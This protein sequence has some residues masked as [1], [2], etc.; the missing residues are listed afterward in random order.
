M[1][2]VFKI[3]IIMVLL[4][5]A[6]VALTL[7]LVTQTNLL[8]RIAERLLVT[9]VESRYDLNVSFGSIG[10][11]LWHDVTIEDV[12]LDFELAPHRY[13]LARIG[14]LRAYYDLRELLAGRW[15]VDSLIIESPVVVLRADTTGKLLLPKLGAEGGGDGVQRSLNILIHKFRV[16]NGRFQWFRIPEPLLLDSIY[17][18]AGVLLAADTIDAQ[19]ESLALRY[20]KK[21]FSLAYLQA[22]VL[23]QP[24]LIAGDSMTIRTGESELHLNAWYP[25]AANS[26]LTAKFSDSHLSLD[27]LSRILKAKITGQFDFAAEVQRTLDRISGNADLEGDLFERKLGPLTTDFSYGDGIVELTNLKGRAFDGTVDGLARLD[28]I[29]RPE[30]FTA[31]LNVKSLNFDRILP[32]TFP[33][34]LSGNVKLRGSGMGENSFALDLQLK[35]G[36]GSFDWVNFD[37]LSGPMTVN[38][39]DLYL[40]RGFRL[41][42]KHSRFYATGMV[43]Y[44]HEMYLMGAFR[45]SQLADFWGDLF[46]EELSGGAYSEFIVSGPL[47][48]PGIAGD[49]RCDSCSFYGYTTDSLTAE[50]NVESFLYGQRGDVDLQGWASDIWGMPADSLRAELTLDSNLIGVKSARTYDRYGGI[51]SVAQVTTHDSTAT[52]NVSDFAWDFDSLRFV[53]SAPFTVEFLAAGIGIEAARIQGAGGEAEF[54]LLY[55]YDSTLDLSAQVDTMPLAPWLTLL[56]VD[57]LVTGR[58]S[59][60]GKLRGKLATPEI[61]VDGKVTDLRAG[62]LIVGELTA[63]FSY[64][65]DVLLVDEARLASGGNNSVLTGYLPLHVQLDSGVV[66]LLDRELEFE[67]QS[68]GNDLTLAS[69]ALPDLEALTGQYT[70]TL[71]VSGTV[72]DLR[73]RGSFVVDSGYVKVYQLENPITNIQAKVFSE[74]RKIF[75][76]WAEGTMSYNKKKGK[77]FA[78]GEITV[79]ESGLLDYDLQMRGTG[80]PIKYD[81]GDIYAY[82]DIDLLEITGSDPPQIEGDVVV[83]EANYFDE[84]ETESVLAAKE[85]ADTAVVVDYV[86][87]VEFLPASIRVRN[88]DINAVLDGNLTVIREGVHDNYIGTLNIIRG[89]YYLQNF[90]FDIEEGSSIIFDDVEQPNPTL[91]IKVSTKVRNFAGGGVSGGQTSVELVIGGTMLQPTIAT[92]EGSQYS[93]EDIISLMVLNSPASSATQNISSTQL[94][95]SLFDYAGMNIGQ[96]LTRNIGIEQVQIVPAYGSDQQLSGAELYLGLYATPNLYTYL[97][98][99]LGFEQGTELG[100]EYRFG[101]NL[102]VGGRRDRDNLYHL[103][104]NLNW[105]FK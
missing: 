77:V 96:T 73:S 37:S 55:G 62:D 14:R 24:G 85:A 67:V 7:Y 53:S 89:K 60:T 56:E 13:R 4:F 30:T 29:A 71:D 18:D 83:R 54:E 1:R 74:D 40:G 63:L 104:L 49:F 88:S 5:V 66:E 47:L 41:D 61:E 10:G 33:S 97:S 46:I 59:A 20:P 80:L 95:Q 101:R 103:N 6:L 100:F 70:L 102:Y 58:L 39:E 11:S 38:V 93:F 42:Y 45:T 12:R 64:S 68:E 52:V 16:D 22:N 34:N 91:N 105:V 27:E 26:E 98:S 82:C 32:G 31:D 8:H 21:D 75:I 76:D 51:N 50:F 99:P 65:D 94:E 28:L 2:T 44:E 86:I 57:T 81:L 48:D 92:A 9:Y 43:S 69:L 23:V 3:P 72:D 17:L 35:L 25:L 19:V 90:T 87:N 36:K 79:L 84:F 15:Q 78:T